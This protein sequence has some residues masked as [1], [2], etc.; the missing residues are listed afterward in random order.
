MSAIICILRYLKG[1]LRKGIMFTKHVNLQSIKVYPDA[2][3]PDAVHDM[4]ST[5]SYFTFVGGNLVIV[6]CELYMHFE[7]VFHVFS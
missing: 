5:S 3:W 6:R 1:A 7:C 4:R 2:N